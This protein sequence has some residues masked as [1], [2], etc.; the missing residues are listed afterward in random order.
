[1][2]EPPDHALRDL[3]GVALPVVGGNEFVDEAFGVNPAERVIAEAEL[4]GVVLRG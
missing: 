3:D 4:S 1:M 2:I